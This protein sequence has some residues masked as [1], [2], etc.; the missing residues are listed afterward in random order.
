MQASKQWNDIFK[1]LKG[2]KQKSCQPEILYLIKIPF[3]TEGEIR[4]FSEKQKQINYH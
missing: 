2:N 3:K 1:V 4:T